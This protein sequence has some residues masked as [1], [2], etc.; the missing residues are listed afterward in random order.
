MAIMT[1]TEFV[2]KARDIATKYKTLYVMG[3]FGAPMNATNKARYCKN[4]SFNKQASRTNKIKSASAD[5]F[6]FDCVCLIK[7][8]LWGWNGNTSK[9][10]G[11][12]Y[13]KTNGVPDVDA[14]AMLHNYCTNISTNFS[15]IVPGELVWMEGH[16]GIYI[17]D[18]LAVECTPKWNDKVQITAVGNIG[19][20][21]GYNT[22][23]WTKHGKSKFISYTNTSNSTTVTNNDSSFATFVK[24]IQSAC[25]AKVDGIPGPETLSKTITI[26][27]T[28]NNR[29]QA[30]K[31]LQTYLKSL[32]YDLGKYGVD[33]CFGN[34]MV[35]AV[36]KFQKNNGLSCCDGVITAKMYTWKKLLKLN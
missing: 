7:A 23:T 11:G 16:I 35:N 1:N 15:N 34:D 8:I 3:C 27:K 9:T 13:Y 29:H 30:I 31:I 10:Y 32:G 21:P 2:Q 22:R 28:K 24:G 20:K 33:G 6:G 19:S 5:T 4:H 17:G 25:G 12:A 36:K 26:S 14:K 18:G